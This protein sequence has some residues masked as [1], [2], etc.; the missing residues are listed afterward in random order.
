VKYLLRQADLVKLNQRELAVLAGWFGLPAAEELALPALA[1]RFG[2][3]AICL[4]HADGGASLWVEGQLFTQ[5]TQPGQAS[6]TPSVL[7]SGN[8]FLAALLHGWLSRQ[9]PADC[10]HQASTA[11]TALAAGRRGVAPTVTRSISLPLP[12]PR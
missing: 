6:S 9:T 7:G 11:A 5:P 3:Q 1:E 2:L 12:A 4:L 8:A 10:L